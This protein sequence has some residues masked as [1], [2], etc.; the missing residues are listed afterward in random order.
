MMV[1]A[2]PGWVSRPNFKKFKKVQIAESHCILFLSTKKPTGRWS[3]KSTA[4]IKRVISENDYDIEN[5]L[6]SLVLFFS[7]D[8]LEAGVTHG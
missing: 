3:R 7:L 6:P 5:R 4:A 2:R 8:W 1:P